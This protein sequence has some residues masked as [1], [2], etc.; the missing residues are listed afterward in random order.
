MSYDVMEMD[1]SRVDPILQIEKNLLGMFCAHKVHMH[2]CMA[3]GLRP[4]H[5]RGTL[6]RQ[7]FEA[8]VKLDDELDTFDWY[9]VG[10]TVSA[11]AKVEKTQK[12]T[13]LL[14]EASALKPEMLPVHARTVIDRAAK[15]E[16]IEAINALMGELQSPGA[17]LD[18]LVPDFQEKLSALMDTKR[19]P[20]YGLVHMS[21][22]LNA[23]LDAMQNRLEGKVT[24]ISTGLMDLDRLIGGGLRSSKLYCIAGRPAMGKSAKG[25]H[26]ITHASRSGKTVFHF[27]LE[28]DNVELG[29]RVVAN[30]SGVNLYSIQNPEEMSETDWSAFSAGIERARED[31]NGVFIDDTPRQTVR[32][33]VREAKRMAVKNKPDV[34]VIDYLGIIG[35]E[36]DE[37]NEAQRIKKMSGE[38]KILSREMKCAVVILAQFNRDTENNSE[39]R[40]L[41]SNLKG[42]GGVEEDCDVVIGLHRPI[43]YDKNFSDPDLCEHIVLKC[44]GGKTGTAYSS[45]HGRTQYFEDRPGYVPPAIEN[46]P[47]Y[48]KRG[49]K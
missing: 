23:Q 31:L 44:R 6:T 14:I 38:L 19:A 20:G 37:Q 29:D 46:T 43:E 35:S 30:Y 15:A 26:L 28:M 33:I 12:V 9:S 24:K 18:D 21:Q 42:S 47:T 32:S 7:I 1:A 40:P 8:C 48:A 2:T 17:S 3:Q 10:Q 22:V 4:H 45:F 25:Q 13:D 34:I 16:M 39:K 5:F 36:R 11:T 49:I 27:S 41:L